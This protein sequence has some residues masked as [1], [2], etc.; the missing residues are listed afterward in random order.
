ME[1][2][3]AMDSAGIANGR[4]QRELAR[5]ACLLPS[6]CSGIIAAVFLDEFL[7]SFSGKTL[8]SHVIPLKLT[9]TVQWP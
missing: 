5:S 9:I 6:K 8:S 2:R 3:Q 1:R 7:V 4:K